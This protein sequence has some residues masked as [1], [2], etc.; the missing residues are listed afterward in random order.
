MKRDSAVVE[1]SRWVRK[2]RM[3]MEREAA[4]GERPL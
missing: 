3:G 1:S 4:G 2:E